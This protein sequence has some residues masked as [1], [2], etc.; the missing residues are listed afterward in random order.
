MYDR[1]HSRMTF[2]EIAIALYICALVLLKQLSSPRVKSRFP[3]K[4]ENRTV[5]SAIQ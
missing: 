2:A 3:L 1:F 4:S 5:T